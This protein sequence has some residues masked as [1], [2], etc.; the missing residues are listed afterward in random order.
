MRA[1]RECKMTEN[2]GRRVS[3]N[4]YGERKRENGAAEK[5]RERDSIVRSVKEQRER[6]RENESDAFYSFL[7]L[8]RD[9]VA[10]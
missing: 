9:S 3:E 4:F 5:K 7:S 1:H 8:E 2:R 6:E 10:F